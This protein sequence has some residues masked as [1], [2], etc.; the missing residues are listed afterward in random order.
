MTD[1]AVSVTVNYVLTLTIAT[2]LLS[3]L[4]VSAGGIIESESERAIQSELEVL[5]QKLAADIESADRLA[6]INETEDTEVESVEIETRLPTWVA[7]TGYTI[8]VNETE[9]NLE[10]QTTSPDVEV[11][12]EFR[13]RDET[14]VEFEQPI[15]GGDV[16]IEWKESDTLV[17]KSA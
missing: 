2:L 16:L 9:R 7:G 1:R 17:V 15:R 14:N 5:G 13:I 11:S 8:T 4:V 3:G 12:V 10:L 6:T